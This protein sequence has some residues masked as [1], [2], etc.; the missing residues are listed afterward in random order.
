M[1]EAGIACRVSPQGVDDLGVASPDEAGS[2]HQADNAGPEL[3]ESSVRNFDGVSGC[4]AGPQQR[5]DAVRGLEG[6]P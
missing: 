4:S 1:S 6:M 2:T 5:L 3:P